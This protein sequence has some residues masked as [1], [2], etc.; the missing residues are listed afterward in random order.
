MDEVTLKQLIKSVKN[1]ISVII[2]I[3]GFVLV[4]LFAF[5]LF[6]S[7]SFKKN[8]SGKITD[9]A[10]STE[11]V[12]GISQQIGVNQVVNVGGEGLKTQEIEDLASDYYFESGDE[13]TELL[14]YFAKEGDST[15]KIAEEILGD[16][17]R[18]IEIEEL[19]EFEPN[20]RLEVGQMILVVK[21]SSQDASEMDESVDF[22]TEQLSDYEIQLGDCLWNIASQ[23]LNDPYR[24]PEIYELNKEVIGSNPDLIYPG[25]QLQLPK[26]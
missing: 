26:I 7:S 22:P 10:A 20:Q 17:H 25:I 16:G 8:A 4:M 14:I 11:N 1:N 19:N 13:S 5:N 23:H 3:L 24:W 2:F 6:L 15:W 12:E 21:D 9:Q 18:Y